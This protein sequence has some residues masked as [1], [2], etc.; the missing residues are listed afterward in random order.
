MKRLVAVALAL[1]LSACQGANMPGAN[2]MNNSQMGGLFGTGLGG[3]LGAFAGSSLGHHSETATL[4]GAGLGALGGYFV[5]TYVAQALAPQDRPRAQ[6]ATQQ[7][8]DEPVHHNR[9][10]QTTAKAAKWQDG[11]TQS[12]GEAHVVAVT[13]EPDGGECRTVREVAYIK[14]QEVT[15]NSRYCRSADGEWTAQSA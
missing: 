14:G 8:L 15:Q 9:S 12:K 4:I 10:G 3:A 11:E 5:G 2:G 6:A 13:Q 1:L 7:V